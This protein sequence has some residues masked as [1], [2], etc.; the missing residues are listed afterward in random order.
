M[1]PRTWMLALAVSTL[2]LCSATS[3]FGQVTGTIKL[4]GK[5]PEPAQIDMSTTKECVDAHPDGIFDESLVVKDGK[6]ANVV[7]SIKPADGQALKGELPKSPVKLDQKGCQYVPHVAAMMVG[8]DLVVANSDP[9]LHNVHSLALDNDGF[10][11]GQPNVDPGKKVPPMKAAERFK[12]KCDVHPWMSC[13][14]S[15]FE[16]PFFAISKPDGTFSIPAGLPDGKYAVVAWQESMGEQEGTVEV[17]GGKGT[18]DFSFK[19]EAAADAGK[20]QERAVTLA[21]LD[22]KKPCEACKASSAQKAA[23]TA[24]A[25]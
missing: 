5:A 17:K 15:V 19:P 9:F 25:K 3:S 2:S 16:H 8:Q 18:V 7:V 14:V 23:N 24:A 21:S 20:L 13:H 10:N 1:K 11:F 22:A 12:I 6:V 4:D